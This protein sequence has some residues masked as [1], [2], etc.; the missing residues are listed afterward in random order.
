MVKQQRRTDRCLIPAVRFPVDPTWRRH[1]TPQASGK[2]SMGSATGSCDG[3]PSSSSIK[4]E[5]ENG[6]EGD[7]GETETKRARLNGPEAA[8]LTKEEKLLKPNIPAGSESSS[9]GTSSVTA[10]KLTL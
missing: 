3:G 2:L 4:A 10:E 5:E 1:P 6:P 9:S 7:S 8:A